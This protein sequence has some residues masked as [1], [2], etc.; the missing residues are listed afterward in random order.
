MQAPGS[1]DAG[2]G[3]DH[4]GVRIDVGRKDKTFREKKANGIML[5]SNLILSEIFIS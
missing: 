5:G 2:S 4:I 1:D 3:S